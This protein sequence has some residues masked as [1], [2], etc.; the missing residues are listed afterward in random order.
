VREERVWTSRSR[1][2]NLI[3]GEFVEAERNEWERV[4]DPASGEVIAEV[5]RCAEEVVDRA[6]EAASRAFEG[7]F[8]TTPAERAEMLH[9]LA[10][11]L[12][13]NAEELA[14]L[15]SKDVG[16]PITS[17]RA[18][19]AR[20]ACHSQNTKLPELGF[21]AV[22]GDVTRELRFERLLTR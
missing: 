15:K 12:Q 2:K 14:R 19:C 16:K 10:D 21:H 7:W 5:P 4:I 13:E 22:L 8:E 6:V 18:G 17:A 20:L 1:I 3:G 9:R 11:V